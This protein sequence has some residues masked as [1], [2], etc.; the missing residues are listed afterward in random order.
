MLFSVLVSVLVVALSFYLDSMLSLVVADMDATFGASIVGKLPIIENASAGQRSDFC[1]AV[2][3]HLTDFGKIVSALNP[4]IIFGG[5]GYLT[6][7]IQKIAVVRLKD[8]VKLSMVHIL[9]EVGI[10]IC[11][12]LFVVIDTSNPSNELLTDHCSEFVAI[13]AE[14]AATIDYAFDIISQ[15]SGVN[16]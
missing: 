15:T 11:T 13:D 3:P 4:I 12:G 2:V 7:V 5:V 1:Q 10:V 6:A 14:Q 8:N 16:F 9:L